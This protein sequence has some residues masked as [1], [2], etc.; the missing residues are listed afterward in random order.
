MDLFD[1]AKIRNLPRIHR[2][3]DLDPLRQ[4]RW[5]FTDKA[6]E[7]F[8][9]FPRVR[10]QGPADYKPV[11]FWFSVGYQWPQF[12]LNVSFKK[13]AARRVTDIKYI[14]RV[15]LRTENILVLKTRRDFT[16]FTEHYGTWMPSHSA[17][18]AYIINW[19]KVA[20]DYAGIECRR[21]E[22]WY[23]DYYWFRDWDCSSGCVW[24]RAGL[25]SIQLTHDLAQ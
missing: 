11:G 18:F 6:I 4:G 21:V 16:E 8:S 15:N 25:R 22:A 12:L 19:R 23:D 1:V 24:H 13:W 17:K 3:L 7:R 5:H 10:E 20:R 9:R 14:Y 2:L